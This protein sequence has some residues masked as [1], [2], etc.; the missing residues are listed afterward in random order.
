MHAGIRRSAAV[1]AAGLCLAALLGQTG[2]AIDSAPFRH[3]AP[4]AVG[5]AP[6]EVPGSWTGRLERIAVDDWQARASRTVFYL[7]GSN[8]SL[9]VSFTEVTPPT[10]AGRLVSVTGL[11]RGNRLEVK[12]WTYLDQAKRAGEAGPGDC[13][14]TGEQKVAVILVSMP[15]RPLLSYVTVDM[16]RDTYFGTGLSLDGFLRESS[17]G[18]AWASGQVLGHVT[19]DA[20]Y[21]GQPTAVRDAA[22]RAAAGLADLTTFDRFALVVPQASTGLSSGGQGSL[23][24]SAI[25]IPNGSVLASTM[26]IGDA[27][28]G[29]ATSR[30]EIAAHELGHNLLLDHARAADFGAEPLGPIGQR[31]IPWDEARVYGDSFSNMGR[32]LGRWAAPHKSRLGWLLD[33]RDVVTVE[34]GGRWSLRPSQEPVGGTR[35]L[36]VRRG[37]GNDA[38]LWIENRQPIGA[39]DAGLPASAFTGALVHYE[40]AG[41]ADPAWATNLARFSADSGLFFG[42]GKRRSSPAPPGA[43][44]PRTS[45][46]RSIAAPAAR[47]TSTVGP[48]RRRPARPR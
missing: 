3:I 9:E 1:G 19:L 10:T 21:I 6:A 8:E 14:T 31:P 29:S 45:R 33:G 43:I 32:G 13:L 15:T 24:C 34:N 42:L 7:T 11:R 30:V 46:S 44:R 39:Y 23:G 41:W 18:A 4:L 27:S 36:R 40:D 5:Q 47:L 20:D 37:T 17:N 48:R 22:L 16:M 25:P 26:W 12:Y 38:W 2:G 35:A 28:L